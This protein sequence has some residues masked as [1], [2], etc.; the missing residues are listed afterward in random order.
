[1]MTSS[2]FVPS[3]ESLS[4]A[5]DGPQAPTPVARLVS[6]ARVAGYTLACAGLLGILASLV[7][8]SLLSFALAAFSTAAGVWLLRAVHQP[9]L[10]GEPSEG[11]TERGQDLS[12]DGAGPLVLQA[13]AQACEMAAGFGRSIMKV[14]AC[15]VAGTGTGLVIIG[16]FALR[17]PELWEYEAVQRVGPPFAPLALGAGVGLLTAEALLIALFG[18]SRS[19]SPDQAKESGAT[20]EMQSAEQGA[21]ADGGRVTSV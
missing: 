5:A 16:V 18:R 20:Q 14:L 2:H 3:R 21:A 1:M 13:V 6:H 17:Q 12:G 11:P 7:S 9:G 8:A 4:P 19:R 15:V 10:A